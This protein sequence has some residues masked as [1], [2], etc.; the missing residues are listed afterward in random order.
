[1]KGGDYLWMGRRR[2]EIVRD[3]FANGVQPRVV[4]RIKIVERCTTTPK[5]NIIEGGSDGCR[6][7]R[8]NPATNNID[9]G[10]HRRKNPAKD[11]LPGGREGRHG[12]PGRDRAE[13]LFE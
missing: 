11:M 2:A 13:R 3:P 10:R 8:K 1:M 9:R 5:E 12:K 7:R 6:H 4:L